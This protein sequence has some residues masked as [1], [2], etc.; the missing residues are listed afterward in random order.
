MST[1][2]VT[3]R[4]QEAKEELSGEARWEGPSTGGGVTG[5]Q[6]RVADDGAVEPRGERAEVEGVED[7]IW[8]W[9]E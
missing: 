7:S 4:A 9:R 3:T 2:D 8:E 1:P 5:M 6:E